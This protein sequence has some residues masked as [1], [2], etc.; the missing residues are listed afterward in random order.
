MASQQAG[1]RASRQ[2]SNSRQVNVFTEYRMSPGEGGKKERKKQQQLLHFKMNV[3]ESFTM[4]ISHPTMTFSKFVQ[5]ILYH[6]TAH[7][8]P[9]VT[10]YCSSYSQ[11]GYFKGDGHEHVS[12]LGYS[13]MYSRVMTLMMEAVCTPETLVYSETTRRYIQEGSLIFEPEIS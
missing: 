8:L 9:H 10:S 11:E 6:Y 7:A 3:P 2:R 4:T 1:G 13:A 12:L 5:Q